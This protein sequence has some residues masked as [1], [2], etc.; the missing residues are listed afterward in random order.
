MDK[1]FADKMV[2]AVDMGSSH[3]TM[4]LGRLSGEDGKLEILG[5]ERELCRGL[6]KKGIMDNPTEVASK[7]N[8]MIKQ[9]KNRTNI[10]ELPQSI[11]ISLGG[12]GLRMISAEAERGLEPQNHVSQSIL[13]E[14]EKECRDKIEKTYVEYSVAEVIWDTFVL[15]GKREVADPLDERAKHILGKY[16]VY[17]GPAEMRYNWIKCMEAQNQLS[18]ASCYAS[19]ETLRAALISTDEEQEGCAIISFGAE[20]TT[21]CA[22][23]RG[24]LLDMCVVPLGSHN[25][26]KDIAFKAISIKDAEALKKRFASLVMPEQVNAIRVKSAINPEES[27][28]FYTNV[29]C[30]I[31]SSREK[32]ILAPIV[33]HINR[34][35]HILKGKTLYITGG[36]A[37]QKGLIPFLQDMVPMDV[38]MGTIEQHLTENT[39]SEFA[40]PEYAQIVGTLLLAGLDAGSSAEIPSAPKENTKGKNK[41]DK[42]FLQRVITLFD[43]PNE[44]KLE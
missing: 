31:V 42:S 29:L 27:M 8:M 44:S 17:C 23:N 26:T 4:M 1:S 40:A 10:A 11:Y 21:Y 39:P 28:F 43:D 2:V 3:I 13:R 9:L 36:G 20:T 32:E 6:A 7:L 30:N 5:A 38:K 33:Q 35:D 14:M 18:I 41:K 34:Y 19:T 37:H 22:Y 12:H 24:K 25:L 15:D 16:E